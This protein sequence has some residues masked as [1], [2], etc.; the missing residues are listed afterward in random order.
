[1]G[2]TYAILLATVGLGVAVGAAAGAPATFN[3]RCCTHSRLVLASDDIRLSGQLLAGALKAEDT[4]ASAQ[5][6]RGTRLNANGLS[7][8]T[9]RGAPGMSD[10]GQNGSTLAVGKSGTQNMVF[11]PEEKLNALSNNL[12]TSP[13]RAVTEKQIYPPDSAAQALAANLFSSSLP[14]QDH[15]KQNMV[16][17]HLKQ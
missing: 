10:L 17:A 16:N 8:L 4:K 2:S 12:F 13:S 9:P 6:P 11:S 1:M 15:N 7:A 3:P 5:P 14:A